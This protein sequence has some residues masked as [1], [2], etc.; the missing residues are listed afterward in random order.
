MEAWKPGSL[1]AAA[2]AA[3]HHDPYWP[4][5]SCLLVDDAGAFREITEISL[6]WVH[7]ARNYK[8]LNPQFVTFRRALANSR[9][10]YGEFYREL[11]AYQQAPSP[12]EAPDS[13]RNVPDAGGT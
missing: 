1:E 8:K 3:Y 5:I 2:V 10:R 4:L 11:Q 9:K 7:D 6:C 12:A 13:S